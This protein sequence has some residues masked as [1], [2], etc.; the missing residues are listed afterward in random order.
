[1]SPSSPPGLVTPTGLQVPHTH[2]D[3][4]LLSKSSRLSGSAPAPGLAAHG[5]RQG[6]LYPARPRCALLLSCICFYLCI[7]FRVRPGQ[8][9]LG[10]LL[11][12]AVD[13]STK[14][15]RLFGAEGGKHG[16]AGSVGARRRSES[17]KVSPPSPHTLRVKT[18]PPSR[19]P[20]RGPRFALH[21][22]RPSYTRLFLP[23][24]ASAWARSFG[25]LFVRPERKN[26]AAAATAAA[27]FFLCPQASKHHAGKRSA[28]LPR[29]HP[30]SKTSSLP[31]CL[32]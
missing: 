15:A 22:I 31:V 10:G 3:V 5:G 24:S 32:P 7:Q 1:M 4:R 20:R 13:V 16:G 11:G 6:D 17:G 12:G 21:L 2:V 8:V 26:T 9:L 19:G 18:F 29:T 28:T 30:L 23:Q 25:P 27:I 14:I